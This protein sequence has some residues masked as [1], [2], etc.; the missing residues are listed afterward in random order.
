MN[1]S[2]KIT[3][4]GISSSSNNNTRTSGQLL[5][6]WRAWKFTTNHHDVR[7]NYIFRPIQGTL[8]GLEATVVFCQV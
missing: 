3:G 2:T 6:Q 8:Y 7:T 4:I 5:I 1:D